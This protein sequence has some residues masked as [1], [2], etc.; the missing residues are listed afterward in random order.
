M[1]FA[2]SSILILGYTIYMVVKEGRALSELYSLWG[3]P[4]FVTIIYYGGDNLLQKIT[5][6]KKKI[7]YEALF[8]DEIGQ[9][10]RESKQ[11]L[12]EEFRKLQNSTKFQE[13]L[14][15]AYLIHQNGETE[16]LTISKLEKRFNDRTLE[17]RAMSFVIKYLQEKIE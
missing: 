10:M 13:S 17:A 6:R 14:R 15:I 16:Q 11:F 5:N 7:D 12:I 1:I 8:L 3:L 2:F 4:F 9:R